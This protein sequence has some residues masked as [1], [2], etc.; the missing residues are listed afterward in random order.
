MNTQTGFER[1]MVMRIWCRLVPALVLFLGLSIFAFAGDLKNERE[2]TS[3]AAGQGYVFF[4]PGAIVAKGSSPGLAQFGGGGEA[5]IYKGAGIG[6][7]LSYVT[8]WSSYSAG[9]GLFSLDGSYHFARSRKISPFVTGGY[10]LA[11]RQGHINLVNFGGG[12]NCWISNRIGIRLELRD[13]VN[14]NTGMTIQYLTAR[15]GLSFR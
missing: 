10:S 2:N 15:I 9:I 6:A 8:P 7:E 1:R 11:F 12:V 4:A 14:R 5:L 13:H 3:R